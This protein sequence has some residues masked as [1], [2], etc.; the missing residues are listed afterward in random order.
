MK[1]V[2]ELI[3][4]NRMRLGITQKQLGELVNKSDVTIR[5]YESNNIKPPL[6]VRIKLAEVFKLEVKELLEGDEDIKQLD[7][8]PNDFNVLANNNGSDNIEFD[9]YDEYL[10]VSKRLRSKLTG[11]KELK[12]TDDL[13]IGNTELLAF[14]EAYHK[15]QVERYIK[16]IKDKYELEL[17]HKDGII[18]VFTQ[19]FNTL[20]Q[21]FNILNQ[22]LQRLK[23][24][25][26]KMMNDFCEILE[27][28]GVQNI[29]DG[30]SEKESKWRGDDS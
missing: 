10:E 7:I 4:E 9:L 28:L 25:E 23:E 19:Q 20:N 29:E 17:A 27:K 22:Q 1:K 15:G 21:Q 24:N 26:I 18:N 8:K 14:L 30:K 11:L 3:K 2:G 5:K 12:R 6:E 13:N 16:H